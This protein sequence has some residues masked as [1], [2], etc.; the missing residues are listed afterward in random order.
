MH[1]AS[2][3]ALLVSNTQHHIKK[4][5]DFANKVREITLDTDKTMVSYD[6]TSLFTY[7]STQEAVI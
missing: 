5:E 3:L 2:I 1:L 7:I 4:S 6:V